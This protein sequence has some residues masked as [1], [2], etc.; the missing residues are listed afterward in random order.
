MIYGGALAISSGA[1]FL[2]LLVWT[3][4]LPPA[5]FGIYAI[6]SGTALFLN[7]LGF[8]WLRQTASRLLVSPGAKFG[9]DP[10]RANSMTLV[11]LSV[12]GITF[13]V[14]AL[15]RGLNLPIAELPASW[16]PV[17]GVFTLSEMMLA[18][19]NTLSRF[20][21]LPWQF[22]RSM[23]SRGFLSLAIGVPLVMLGWG[24]LGAIL[25]IVLAQC[26]VIGST[27]LLDRFWRTLRPA[28]GRR[29]DVAA[30]LHFGL[31]L[32]A[33]SGANYSVGFLDRYMVGQFLG[34]KEVG[35]Y[36]A[37]FDL[38]QKTVV[39][40]L[41][42]INLTAGPRIF[43]AF[44]A[45]GPDAARHELDQ[46][47]LLL[48][49]VGLPAVVGLA[50]LSPGLSGIL[51]GPAYRASAAVLL[52]LIATAVLLRSLVGFHISLAFQLAKRTRLLVIPPLLSVVVLI[53]AG[54]FGL[55]WYG[56]VGMACAAILA[57][58]FA[59]G[60]SLAMAKRIFGMRLPMAQ[61]W[62]VIAAAA[63]MGALL[64]PL[65]GYSGALPTLGL[66]AAGGT[67]YGAALLLFGYPPA[68][69]ILARLRRA[70]S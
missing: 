23:A 10:G 62:R 44:E 51:M 68:R 52:P 38:M 32:I 27:L 42:A 9:V 57:Q 30:I 12:V 13:V 17:I 20:R 40:L 16:W 25:G 55:R 21:M 41:L 19:A 15:G 58:G 63:C 37:P 5:Q 65:R 61:A 53:L 26:L 29:A 54:Y 14:I 24:A 45:K 35:L 67:I 60:L 34:L 70:E 50:A 11:V 6:A 46:N 59:F 2:A 22:F 18:L 4:L 49:G 64:W 56:L 3:R 7:A 39:F 1:N 28:Q 43:L 66:V 33:S 36:S 8:E 47:F 48:L 31:P 69:A